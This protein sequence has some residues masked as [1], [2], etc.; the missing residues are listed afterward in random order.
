MF[1]WVGYP[2]SVFTFCRYFF[3]LDQDFSIDKA[4]RC[5]TRGG[6]VWVDSMLT[7]AL[8]V[9]IYG[10]NL[11]TRICAHASK[12][13]LNINEMSYGWRKERTKA[14]VRVEN[15]K[16]SNK[17][18][19]NW[20]EIDVHNQLKMN[21]FDFKRMAFFSLQCVCKSGYNNHWLCGYTHTHTRRHT[22]TKNTAL[23]VKGSVKYK[24]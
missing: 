4:K 3:A 22:C 14:Q 12:R 5:G 17:C 23:R 6:W 11:W 15:N 13:L 21:T 7:N 1:D 9:T 20:K 16:W 18:Q 10:N 2:E 24:L 19:R 8:E